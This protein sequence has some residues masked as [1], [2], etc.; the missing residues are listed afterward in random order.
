[1]RE[2]IKEL[3]E[4]LLVRNGYA[5]FRFQDLAE[6]LGVTR[7]SI[8]YHFTS[9]QRLCEEVI[10]ES[11]AGSAARYEE[12]L[13]AGNAT[14]DE[15]VRNIMRMNRRRYLAYNAGG[16]GTRSWALISRMRL[17]QDELTPPVREALLAFRKSLEKN[18]THA[19]KAAVDSGELAKSVPVDDLVMLFIAIVNS[20]DATTRDTGSFRR[21]EKLYL[22]FL[23]ITKAAYG[24]R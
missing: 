14:F 1:M 4:N 20:S 21:M 13:T 8:H 9:K 6:E 16:T 18:L 17:D 24:R 7:A 10:L 23:R 2:K 12:L 5:G 19:V 15:R 11:V 22:A 3:A